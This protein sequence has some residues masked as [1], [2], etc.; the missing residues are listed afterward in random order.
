V[1]GQEGAISRRAVP[2]ALIAVAI[3][4][5]EVLVIALTG[6]GR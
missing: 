5:I 6:V 1:Q 3:V 4:G 2:Y